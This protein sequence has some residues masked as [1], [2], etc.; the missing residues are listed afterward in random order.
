MFLQAV[1]KVEMAI[2][3]KGDC[4]LKDLRM[5]TVFNHTGNNEVFNSVHNKVYN[6]KS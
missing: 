2:R 5:M 6:S 1:R 4:R 3:G